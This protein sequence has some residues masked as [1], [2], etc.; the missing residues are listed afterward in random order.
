M[1][2]PRIVALLGLAS[3]LD[4][5]AQVLVPILLVRVLSAHDFG[6]YRLLWLAA[7]T[8]AN[9][10]SMSVAGLLANQVPQQPAHRRGA[11]FGNAFAYL[12]AAALLA[13][14][15]LSPLTPLVQRMYAGGAV[16][17]WLPPLFSALWLVSLPL[18]FVALAF[19]RPTDQ[20]LLSLGQALL[21]IGPV[22]AAALLLRNLTGVGLALIVLAAARI[23]AA[24]IYASRRSHLEAG[25]GLSL[26]ADLARLQLRDGLGFGTGFMLG[27]LR[28]QID[29]WVAALRF[30]PVA[31]AIQ[32][33]ALAAAPLVNILRMAVTNA[34]GPGIAADVAAGR[35]DAAV[36]ANRRG[37]LMVAALL[38]PLC[39]MLIALAGPLL[40]FVFT[41]RFSAAVLPFRIYVGGLLAVAL[42]TTTL[43][44][45]LRASSLVLR[46]GAILLPLAAAA[47]Y[48]G[49][50]VTRDPTRGLCGIAIGMAAVGWLAQIW[51]LVYVRRAL[52][53]AWAE[54]QAWGNLCALFL[55][56]LGAT[57]FTL[58]I[59]SGVPT[60]WPTLLQL[61]A[62]GT[63]YLAAALVLSLAWPRVWH[64]YRDLL[65]A[66]RAR[67]G[68][69]PTSMS[70]PVP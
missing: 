68:P 65:G 56:N 24:L 23:L 13:A 64:V 25:H 45:A 63:T 18:D 53:L 35:V 48:V 32:G 27:N 38:F 5:A 55:V 33:V 1:I 6:G 47:C 17:A 39:G 42:E 49:A 67:G 69:L 66:A 50:S 12:A 61:L 19:Q 28:G 31:V 41:A 21:R 22:V 7:Q 43:T 44:V 2:R 3:G 57:L 14:L 4:Y 62:G 37:N 9:F 20:A 15:L 60:S 70:G 16:D 30:D 36:A 34:I 8:C 59:M 10:L 11:L 51:N 40:V 52:G 29:G 46:Q 54:F 58:A 26:D